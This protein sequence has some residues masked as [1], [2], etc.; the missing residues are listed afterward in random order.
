MGLTRKLLYGS[1]LLFITIFVLNKIIE[2]KLSN[3]INDELQRIF[4]NQDFTLDNINNIYMYENQIKDIQIS[5]H[6][7]KVNPIKGFLEIKKPTL[8]MNQKNLSIKLNSIIL[9]SGYSQIYNINKAVDSG[10]IR[11]INISELILKALEISD[12]NDLIK[13]LEERFRIYLL[14]KDFDHD[15]LESCLKFGNFNN[16]YLVYLKIESL[17][18]FKKSNDFKKLMNSY[19]RPIN[20]LN[21][22]EKKNNFILSDEPSKELFENKYEKVLFERLIQ[23]EIEV[24]ELIKKKNFTLALTSLST[25]DDEIENFFEN[26]VI[27]V[28]KVDIK[29]NR[30]KLCNKIRKLMHSVAYFGQL[31]F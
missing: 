2:I 13:F 26:V 22:E 25:F 14:E 24:S 1:I 19:K 23:V 15:L 16:P 17:K 20:I 27:N 4:L 18:E 31:N 21:S 10:L 9:K 28:D 12:A 29:I 8:K 3:D 6:G 5:Y 7:I 30:L 11:D